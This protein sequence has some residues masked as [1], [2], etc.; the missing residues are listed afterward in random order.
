VKMCLRNISMDIYYFFIRLII[1]LHCFKYHVVADFP[2]FISGFGLTFINVSKV[3]DQLYDVIVQTNEV[4][5]D[6]K[7]R[8]LLPSDYTTSGASRHYPVLYLL[9]GAHDHAESWT[10]VGYAQQVLGNLS[11][12]TV[13]PNG[14][15]FGWYTNW[16]YPGD[17]APQ[18]WRTF[19]NEQII[20]WIDLNL[21][22]IAKKEGRAIAGLSMGGFGAIRYAEVYPQLFIYAAS[23]SGTLNLLD[24][25]IQA[26]VVSTESS[27]K[28]P[29]DGPFGP[30]FIMTNTS[31]WVLQDAVTHAEP[32]R[33]MNISLYTG[34]VGIPE[35][36][37]WRSAVHMHDMLNSL[38]IPHFYDNYGD[39]KSIGYDCHG[40]HSWACWHAALVDVT[41][42][43]MAVLQQQ[44]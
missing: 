14:D 42:H 36:D 43:I 4:K 29:R 39:G 3:N 8:I 24:V 22:T 44:F 9:H 25:G 30:P 33:G 26:F 27:D 31:G 19:H 23:F 34:D 35:V 10:Q 38:N 41:P 6:Q 5:D 2:D 1:I 13:M 28:K 18:N 16:L 32:L 17:A 12:I 21:R 11:L 40:T 7:I 20:P 15:R 37:I